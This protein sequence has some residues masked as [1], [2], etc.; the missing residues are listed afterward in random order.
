MAEPVDNRRVFSDIHTSG[1]SGVE[2]TSIHPETRNAD[3]GFFKRINNADTFQPVAKELSTRNPL[4]APVMNKGRE[5]MIESVYSQQWNQAHPGAP[6]A[7]TA[8]TADAYTKYATYKQLAPSGNRQQT[9][10][11]AI[12]LTAP[13]PTQA[14]QNSIPLPPQ[15][16][17]PDARLAA[18]ELTAG[19]MRERLS[20]H[21]TRHFDQSLRPDEKDNSPLHRDSRAERDAYLTRLRLCA[22]SNSA[23]AQRQFLSSRGF[24]TASEATLPTNQIAAKVQYVPGTVHQ[25]LVGLVPTDSIISSGDA[26]DL[27]AGLSEYE[28]DAHQ[29]VGSEQA[30]EPAEAIA[31]SE[32]RDYDATVLR[33]TL[34]ATLSGV[35]ATKWGSEEASAEASASEEMTQDVEGVPSSGVGSPYDGELRALR[36]KL[37]GMTTRN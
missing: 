36:S 19:N 17:V 4:P 37:L 31:A 2:G 16:F 23:E 28:D 25:R 24:E 1:K 14:D 35:P 21:W 20:D 8:S 32:V 3:A 30:P 13:A 26:A 12:K 33:P 7:A 22:A 34:E 15:H 10:A 9:C 6:V 29:S 27:I 18:G 11:S 5:R